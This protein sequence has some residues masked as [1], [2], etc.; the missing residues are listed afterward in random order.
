MREGNPG[1]DGGSIASIDT[2]RTILLIPFPYSPLPGFDHH[3]VLST[4]HHTF[5]IA[6]Y[7]CSRCSKTMTTDIRTR[8]FTSTLHPDD[9]VGE[10]F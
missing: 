2:S 4:F 6:T 7:L 8:T 10:Q 3:W 1:D 5:F 9:P